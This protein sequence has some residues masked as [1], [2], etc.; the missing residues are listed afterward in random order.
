[1]RIVIDTKENKIICP[2][3]FW[4]EVQKKKDI[5]KEINPEEAAKITHHSEVRKYFEAAIE[6]ELVRAQDVKKK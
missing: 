4:D 5:V 3:P 1:M 6:N 2:K